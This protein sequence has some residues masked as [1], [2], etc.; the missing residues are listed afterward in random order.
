MLGSAHKY[1]SLSVEKAII[2]NTSFPNKDIKSWRYYS[3][4]LL[5]FEDAVY[6]PEEQLRSEHNPKNTEKN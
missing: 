3:V 6:D 4:V 2:I 1:M 5:Q